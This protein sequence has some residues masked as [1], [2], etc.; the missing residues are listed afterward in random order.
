MATCRGSAVHSY[1][2]FLKIII[3]FSNTVSKGGDLGAQ[4]ALL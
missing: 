1:V 4:A 3:Y 2:V